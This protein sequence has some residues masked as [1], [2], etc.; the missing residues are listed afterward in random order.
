MGHI[1]WLFCMYFHEMRDVFLLSSGFCFI[2]LTVVDF[3]WQVY[4]NY[5]WISVI[6]LR[7]TFKLF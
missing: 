7:F 1:F 2:Y 4:I 6:F 5:L 3:F